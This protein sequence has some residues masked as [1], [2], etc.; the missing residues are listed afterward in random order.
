MAI[1][2]QYGQEMNFARAA[3]LATPMVEQF[4]L[5]NWPNQVALNINFSTQALDGDSEVHVVP[6]ETN[7]LGYKYN[8]GRDPKGRLFYWANNQPEPEPS[9]HPTDASVMKAGQISVTPLS[10]NLNQTAAI[11]QFRELVQNKSM[12][13]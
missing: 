7:P 10:F 9:P 13:R 8:E 6:M 5:E 11:E 3:E 4:Y 1:S 12:A 2:I